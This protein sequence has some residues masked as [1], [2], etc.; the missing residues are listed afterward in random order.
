MKRIIQMQKHLGKE[1][2]PSLERRQKLT[3]KVG[4]VVETK[5]YYEINLPSYLQHDLEA[6]KE[7]KY[8]YDCL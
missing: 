5:E 1:R 6:M 7:G 2:I 4:S 8:L 3:G